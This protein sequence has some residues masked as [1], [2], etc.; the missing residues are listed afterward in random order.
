MWGCNIDNCV[1][2]WRGNNLFHEQNEGN[3]FLFF[4]L[5][6]LLSYSSSSSPISCRIH[7]KSPYHMIVSQ[8]PSHI[9]SSPL[10]CPEYLHSILHCLLALPSSLPLL[11]WPT[12]PGA[13]LPCSP[14]L[15]WAKSW[16]CSGFSPSEG[17]QQWL[18]QAQT[19]RKLVSLSLPVCQVCLKL[20][21]LSRMDRWTDYDSWLWQHD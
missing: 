2:D 6:L 17:H 8:G 10:P 16:G 12:V 19:W 21:E 13:P 9:S 15:G 18:S 20:A 4:S 1:Y 5:Y 3:L 14:G 7:T 11:G